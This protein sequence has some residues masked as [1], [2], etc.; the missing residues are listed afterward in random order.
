MEDILSGPNYFRIPRFQRPFSWGGKHVDEFWHDAIRNFDEG[1][2]I[3]PMV[4]YKEDDRDWGVVDGQQ[5]LTIVALILVALRDNFEALG[6]VGLADATHRFIERPDPNGKQRFVLQSDATEGPWI[7]HMQQRRSNT[8]VLRKT[9]FDPDTWAAYTIIS[10]SMANLVLENAPESSSKKQRKRA[11]VDVLRQI[12]DQIL[13][14]TVIWVPLD[15]EDDAYEFFETLNARGKDLEVADRLKNYFLSRLK[16]ANVNLDEHRRRWNGL[17]EHFEGEPSSRDLNRFILHWWLSRA[18]YVAERK[19]FKQ[20][21][22]QMDRSDVASEFDLF[23]K[24]AALYRTVVDPDSTI[25]PIERHEIRD[26][27]RGL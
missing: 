26:A 14:L 9:E 5:R 10:E 17:R 6:E 11:Q 8:D 24:D 7:N 13:S 3:G 2:F 4:V 25:W 23:E 20:M 16:A 12:R 27:L 19:V 18:P 22:T 21:K 15:A 1:Y